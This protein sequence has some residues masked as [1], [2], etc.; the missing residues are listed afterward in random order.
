MPRWRLGALRTPT[1]G[2][3]RLF[4]AIRTRDT[5]RRRFEDKP[6]PQDT[7]LALHEAAAAEGAELVVLAEE[8]GRDR[9]AELVAEGDRIHSC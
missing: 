4:W 8:A 3:E 7:L 6:V 5:N 1:R 2:E 9:L